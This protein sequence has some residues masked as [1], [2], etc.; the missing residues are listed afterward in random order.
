MQ[1]NL[2]G[3][4]LISLQEWTKEE[5]DTVLDVALQLKRER[6]LGIGPPPPRARALPLPSSFSSTPPRA[7]HAPPLAQL[8]PAPPLRAACAPTRRTQRMHLRMRLT[9]TLMP[10]FP[11]HLALTHNNAA[12]ARIRRCCVQPTA[13]QI[14]CARHITLF[15]FG[16]NHGNL[17][18]AR[19]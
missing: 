6:A 2:R 7:P 11:H 4:D 18:N 5:I 19:L 8:V 9:G 17:C 3:R 15:M 1:T 10:T 13:R 16:K 12:D 14:Q